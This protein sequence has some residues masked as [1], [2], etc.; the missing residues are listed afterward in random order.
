MSLARQV[1]VLGALA[2]RA[3]ASDNKTL[4]ILGYP[5]WRE[6]IRDRWWKLHEF[7]QKRGSAPSGFEQDL[8]PA[9]NALTRLFA[10]LE[11]K[12]PTSSLLVKAEFEAFQSAIA[13]VE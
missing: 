4:D 1:G 7:V 13:R 8:R 11:G 10:L 12:R 6:A 2:A 9:V 3:L 5:G